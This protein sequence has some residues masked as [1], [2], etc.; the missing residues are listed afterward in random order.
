MD[1][2]IST[3][4]VGIYSLYRGKTTNCHVQA[5]ATSY[6][7][8]FGAFELWLLDVLTTVPFGLIYRPDDP[9]RLLDCVIDPDLGLDR[10]LESL[11][12]PFEV[13][14]WDVSVD[15]AE[16][17]SVLAD[18]IGAGPV[19]LGPLDMGQLP[20]F[21]HGEL[22]HGMDHYIVATQLEIE[23]ERLWVCDP[24][25]V[26][27]AL[28]SL[29]ELASAWLATQ[30]PEGRG[31]Y[32]MRRLRTDHAPRLSDELFVCTCRHLADN[33]NRAEVEKFGGSGGLRAI[34][35][36]QTTIVEQPSLKRGLMYTIPTR[37][38]RCN[39]GMRFLR[40]LAEQLSPATYS[41]RLE[42]CSSIL[43]RQIDLLADVLMKVM[44]RTQAPLTS[45]YEVADLEYQLT[46][47]LTTAAGELT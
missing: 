13:A 28:I 17:L 46:D 42:Q 29:T 16:P 12:I 9:N 14:C 10:A 22:Y 7:H 43:A 25:A 20:Y 30:V 8:V 31:A 4:S 36:T 27:Y 24:E 2:L 45:L 21:F 6:P 26:P 3:D 23:K 37:I 32:M 1:S 11:G 33:L 34:A 39:A 40:A 35:A 19:V 44:A 15:F 5:L 41:P 38:Q 47:M 18:W